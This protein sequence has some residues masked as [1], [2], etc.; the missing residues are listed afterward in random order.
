V[1][2][3]DRQ[4][5]IFKDATASAIQLLALRLTPASQQ[6]IH[7]TNLSSLE[8]WYDTYYFVIEWFLDETEVQIT[9]KKYFK[10]Q[11]LKKTIMTYNYAATEFTC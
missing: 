8:Y 10:R 4:Y 6:I 11:Y 3:L 7:Y 5:I 9:S 1:A 2:G